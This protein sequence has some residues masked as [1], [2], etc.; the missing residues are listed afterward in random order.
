MGTSQEAVDAL[1]GIESFVV[2]SYGSRDPDLTQLFRPERE[3]R[4]KGSLRLG[5]VAVDAEKVTVREL[6][7]HVQEV[8]R[9]IQAAVL[10][11]LNPDYN[12]YVCFDQL[13]LGFTADDPRYAQR[14]IGL[15]LAAREFSRV[16]N[17]AGRRMSVVVLLRDDIY[18]MLQF[19][20]KNKITQNNVSFVEWDRGDDLTLRALMERRF[21]EVL[22]GSG[23]RAWDSV[24]DESR[25]M[26]S[27]Q[28]KYKHIVDRTF[29][30][31][32]DM[33]KFCNEVLAAYKAD[34]ASDNHAMFDNDSV[35]AA[36]DSYSDYLLHE[37]DDEIAKHVPN[38]REYLEVLKSLGDIQFASEQFREGW[39]QRPALT[40][41]DWRSGLG[42]LFE[43]SVIGYLKSGGGGGGSK[44]VWRYLDS[45]ARFD[46]AAELYRVHP[47]FKEALDL[48]QRRP[49]RGDR[50]RGET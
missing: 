6:P 49:R 31:P 17:E 10:K 46:P 9:T 25:E 42:S 26:P 47:G 21:G 37:L 36:R 20:D 39:D 18:H 35:I 2:D 41:Q 28:T 27:R 11:A 34:H 22:A 7:A 29:L 13:D 32:R 19:E 14:L 50:S 44:Y 12:Y 1:E 16:A 23:A 15:L 33:I 38:Y 48:V 8:N 40:G 24:F 5:V 4:F 30:R 3:L 45:R 43:F